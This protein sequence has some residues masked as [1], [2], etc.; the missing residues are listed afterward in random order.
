VEK[1]ILG[2][3]LTN[4]EVHLVGWF[5]VKHVTTKLNLDMPD[6]F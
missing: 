5:V 6:I 2:I 3:R 4:I 1:G